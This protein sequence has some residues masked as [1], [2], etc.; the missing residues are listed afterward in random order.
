MMVYDRS[1]MLLAGVDGNS[2]LD[3][4]RMLAEFEV[5]KKGMFLLTLHTIKHMKV[6]IALIISLLGNRIKC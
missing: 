4:T 3:Q 5:S 1:V 6:Q 2:H